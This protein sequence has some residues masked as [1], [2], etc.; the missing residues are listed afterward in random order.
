MSVRLLFLGPAARW[1]GTRELSVSWRP[2]NLRDLLIREKM[3]A[4]LGAHPTVMRIA[5]NREFADMETELR[6]GDEVAF[7][8][9]V[10]GG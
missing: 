5:V 10:S 2:G 3:L 7:I 4:A 9:P 6:E 1:A 8:P